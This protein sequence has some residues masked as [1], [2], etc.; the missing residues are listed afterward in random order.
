M[1]TN[2]LSH[3]IASLGVPLAYRYTLDETAVILG[4]TPKQVRSQIKKGRL[5]GVRG[6]RNHVAGVLHT[7]LAAY[8][9]AVNAKGGE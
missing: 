2:T 9:A 8:F 7:D 6:S 4:L 3:L 1:P 5:K